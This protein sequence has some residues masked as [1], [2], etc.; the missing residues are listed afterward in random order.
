MY[1]F[2]T[3]QYG[4]IILPSGNYQALKV[5]IGS[6]KGAN[7]WCVLFPPLCIVDVTHGTISDSVK[8]ELKNVLTYDEYEIIS[9]AEDDD[10]IP[11]KVKFK[12]VEFFRFRIKFLD[13]L[14]K[15]Q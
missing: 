11:V 7:W 1:P 3:K 5:V 10:D 4:D 15:F 9:S 14:A 2:P 13:S 12:I 8:E 6:G